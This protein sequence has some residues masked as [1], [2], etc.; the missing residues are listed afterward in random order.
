MSSNNIIEVKNLNFK[1]ENSKENTIN[2]VSFNIKRGEWVSVI[3]HNGSGKSTLIKLLDG[4]LPID[5]GS[6]TINDNL[7]KENNLDQIRKSIGLVFQNPDNQFVGATVEDDIAFGLENN[8][9]SRNDMNVIIDKVLKVVD[10]SNYRT[11]E[12]SK[13]SGGQKQRIALAGVLA[14]SPK[15]LILDEATSMI[16]PQGRN[17]ILDII[18]NFRTDNNM[19]VISIT[20]DVEEI[21]LS[22]R[23]LLLKS[24]ML[25]EDTNPYELFN[26]VENLEKYSLEMPFSAQLSRHLINSGLDIPNSYM[27]EEELIKCI[28]KLYLKM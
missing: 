17:E 11:H 23:V 13:L 9:F 4:L 22:S 8:Q 2:D 25:I 24:G 27:D 21:K 26:S 12:P 5:S 6:I 7:V 19:T 10:M 18:N 28:K 1:Y 16:D 3:G 20:H 15:I 14:L